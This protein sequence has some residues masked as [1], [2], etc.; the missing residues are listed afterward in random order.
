MDVGVVGLG[1]IGGS[2][3][4]SLAKDLEVMG[5]DD[6]PHTLDQAVKAG[7]VTHPAR[8]L[9]EFSHPKL[10]FVAAPPLAAPLVI[11][12]LIPHVGRRAVITDCT[13]VKRHL[14]ES[15]S[16]DVLKRFVGGHPMAGREAGGFA[17]SRADL[18]EGSSWILTPTDETEPWCTEMVAQ[19]VETFGSRPELMSVEDHDRLIALV[20]QL[21]HVLAAALVTQASRMKTE[22]LTAGSWA[23]LTRVAGSDP[24]VWSDL[25]LLNQDA[26]SNTLGR[27]ILLLQEFQE[28]LE[29]ADRDAVRRFFERARAAKINS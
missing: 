10:I 6:D 28:E 2:I 19:T 18:F 27:L 7:A 29:G 17:R 26:L 3:A 24:S 13:G 5:F 22:G 20:S 21:P 4:R 23:D 16:G 11:Q 8:S 1:L 25:C 12:D 9:A 15:L 14:F